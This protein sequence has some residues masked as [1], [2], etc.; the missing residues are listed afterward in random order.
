MSNEK[1]NVRRAIRKSFD[2][3]E[4]LLNTWV[5]RHGGSAPQAEVSTLMARAFY[6]ISFWAGVP[7]QSKTMVFSLSLAKNSLLTTICLFL[8]CI[9]QTSQPASL[10]F[11]WFNCY[12]DLLDC[13]T[14][15]RYF[16]FIKLF[17]FYSTTIL[18]RI[19]FLNK[20]FGESRGFV[21]ANKHWR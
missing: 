18:I 15:L 1:A 10:R 13:P 7:L 3:V 21:I 5:G 4:S 6:I 20:Q 8:Y 11:N 14:S 9:T 16:Y 19:C 17:V 2:K 12:N